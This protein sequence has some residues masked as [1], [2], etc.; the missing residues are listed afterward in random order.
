MNDITLSQV[1]E[2]IRGDFHGDGSVIVR[3][4]STD[5]RTLEPGAVYF[6]FKGARVDGN[7]L[8]AQALARGG[9][10]VVTDS[11]S[12][13]LASGV[14]EDRLI[15]VDDVAGALG[16]AARAHLA[17]LRSSGNPR[18][19]VVAVT[20]SVGK[21]TT[22]DLLSAL[23]ASRG[24]IIAPPGSFNNELGLPLTV[25]RA[26]RT[27]A[28]LVLEMGADHIGNINYLTS[29]AP[30]D[31]C[32]VLIVA[33]AHVGEFGSMDNIAHAKSEL[34]QGTRPGGHVILN[35]DDPRVAAMA[36]QAHG[37]VTFF[38]VAHCAGADV[39][40]DDVELDSLGRAHFTL[41][42]GQGS[43]PVALQLVGRHHVA[44]ALAAASVALAYE[45]PV[46]EIARVL[47]AARAASPHRMD[48][49]DVGGVTIIDD[50]YNANPD[51]MRAGIAALRTIGVRR[52]RIAV[53]GSMLELGE[54][55]EDEHRALAHSLKEA[56]T[57]I[58]VTIGHETA[59]LCSEAVAEGIEVHS[60]PNVS[61]AVARVREILRPGDV[62]LLKGSN[63]SGVWRI[64]D[65]LL[66]GI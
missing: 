54:S 3:S 38:S 59:P 58:L 26:D 19:Q 10:A 27:T 1:A 9:V 33:R 43:A 37:P 48:V 45:I 52:R 39:W 14:P 64:A 23:L 66:R 21:T 49:R 61:D 46:Q 65:E 31:A 6:A 36:Q 30:P 7:A 20:G 11:P 29:I 13:A 42:T 34:V 44:N 40:A 55:S 12:V 62:V 5:T 15:V 57:G 32:A 53:L 63:G 47:G 50:S 17:R 56:G 8:A 16:D 18:L 51:S 25:L 60:A 28:T 41:G 22:K 35:K 4:V 24:P 2:D